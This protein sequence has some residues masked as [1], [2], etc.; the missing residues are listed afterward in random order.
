MRIGISDIYLDALGGGEKYMLSLAECLSQEH[1]VV[2]FW[3][4]PEILSDVTR[5]FALDMSNV[6]IAPSLFSS[7]IPTKDR[8]LK[9]REYDMIIHLSDGSIP[10]SLAKR[11]LLHIQ[12]PLPWI[13]KLSF[14]DQIKLSLTRGII[15]NSEFTKKYADQLFHKKN[16]VLYPP[17]QMIGVGTAKDDVILTVGRYNHMESGGDF[18]KLGRMVDMFKHLIDQTQANWE[19]ILVVTY[20][21]ADK[22]YIEELIE[23][24]KGYNISF[25]TNVTNDELAILYQN[26]KI[27]WHAAGFEEDLEKNPNLAEHFGIS[28]VEAMSAGAVPVVIHAGGIPEFVKDG[29]NGYTWNTEGEL[30]KKTQEV[31][32]NEV[33]SETLSKDA[34]ETAHQFSQDAFREHV[35]DVLAL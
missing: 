15:Y 18:K 27:Y 34:I 13:K 7:H 19:L 12:H 11:T 8:L 6:R 29:K 30:L 31:M 3:D 21:D 26:A 9:T 4:H 5:R 1:D 14:F 20:K 35:A 32:R 16:L 28:V 17:A 24:A 22:A 2:L 33:L 25:K 23:H 10:L